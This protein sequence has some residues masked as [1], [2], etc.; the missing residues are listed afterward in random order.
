MIAKDA[1]INS[2]AAQF[3]EK[4]KNSG[5]SLNS[6]EIQAI[7][8]LT[9]KLIEFNL[10]DK[11][12]AI[13]PFVGRSATTHSFNLKNFLRHTIKWLN[14]SSL[15][16]DSSGVTNNSNGYG[17]TFVAPSIFSDDNIHVSVYNATFWPFLNAYSPII[18]TSP[19]N[20]YQDAWMHTIFLKFP[21]NNQVWTYSSGPAPRT[22]F[23][24][25]GEDAGDFLHAQVYGLVVGV[26]GS[27]C[28]LNGEPFGYYDPIDRPGKSFILN[29]HITDDPIEGIRY[30]WTPNPFMLF[31][32]RSFGDPSIG[33][34]NANIR[35]ASIGYGLNDEDNKNLYEI[36]EQFQ[37]ILGRNV[38]KIQIQPD[39]FLISEQGIGSK[40][41]IQKID[42]APGFFEKQ[43]VISKI[44]SKLRI[45]DF[46]VKGPRRVYVSDNINFGVTLQS[47]QELS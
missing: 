34:A 28:Y 25:A 9:T 42:I 41:N 47:F 38:G 36:V 12:A 21:S 23:S 35:F 19:P 14:E 45:V 44:E 6:N 3:I 2:Y 13:Y 37:T 5:T 43:N 20:K 40:I 8:F 33:Y 15:L 27:K 4:C 11:F 31:T 32:H 24:L 39:D 29:P 30:D 16:H 18:G 46:R 17:N 26:N 7:N 1:L 10:W 22:T